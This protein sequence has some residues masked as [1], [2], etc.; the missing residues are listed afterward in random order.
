[1]K[2]QCQW[3]FY[4]DAD[5]IVVNV[6]RSPL[7]LLKQLGAGGHNETQPSLYA[8]CHTP[9]GRGLRSGLPGSVVASDATR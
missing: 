9:L 2:P 5:A 6:L 3:V 1:M 4:I 8:T 7:R